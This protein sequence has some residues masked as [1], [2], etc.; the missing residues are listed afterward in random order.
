MEG[1]QRRMY[2]AMMG[3]VM[4]AINLRK[5]TKIGDPT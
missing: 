4:E 3:M 1:T 2:K 5:A